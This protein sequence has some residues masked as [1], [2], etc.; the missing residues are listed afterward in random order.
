MR[1]EQLL[2][3]EH[4]GFSGITHWL[5]SIACFFM[6][7]LLP[8]P[9][10]EQ[11]VDAILRS[12]LFLFLTF[13]IIGGAA[14]LPDLD[15]SPLQE[16][17]S[18]A[19]YQLGFLGNAL[20]VLCIVISSVIWQVF[21][22][23]YDEKPP[24]QHRMLF[25]AGPFCS[26]CIF[27]MAHLSLPDGGGSVISDGL[28]NANDGTWGVIFLGAISTYLGASMFFYKVLSLVGKQSKTQFFCLIF[29]GISVWQMLYMPYDQ[30][31]LVGLTIALGYLFHIIPGDII[32]K[33][34]SPIFFP[35]PTPVKTS[36]GIKFKFWRKPYIGGR[37]GSK[38]A[39][40]TG[41][42]VNIILNFLLAGLDIFL[43][44]YIFIRR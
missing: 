36:K 7:F 39:I 37:I 44:Y 14:L 23:R 4:G 25:H 1:I 6:I 26:A 34:S 40:E 33:G 11:Y 38:L 2:G 3:E 16:G 31:K 32:S 28:K 24:S 10:A 35:I 29:M 21:H 18:T 5:M 22:T 42:A 19:V 9:F 12:K 20:S 17:G 43:F 15:S 41:G 8:I 13:L 30:L 27:L